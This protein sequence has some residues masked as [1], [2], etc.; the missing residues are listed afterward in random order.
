[1]EEAAPITTTTT[2]TSPSA[3]TTTSPSA[4]AVVAA[5]MTATGRVAKTT[6][7][8][9]H[10]AAVEDDDDGLGKATADL[11]QLNLHG[12]HYDHDHDDDSSIGSIGSGVHNSFDGIVE[13]P[14]G[15]NEEDIAATNNANNQVLVATKENRWVW[16]LRFL[17]TLIMGCVMIAVCVTVYYLSRRG[18]K[19]DFEQDF[20][21]IGDKLVTSFEEEIL[22][23]IGL[24]ESFADEITANAQTTVIMED[25]NGTI[26]S[27]ETRTFPFVTPNSF[28]R[29]SFVVAKMAQLANVVWMPRVE[30]EQLQEWNQYSAT[31]PNWKLEGMAV[32]LNVDP[33]TLEGNVSPLP[34]VLM[35]FHWGG[36]PKPEDGVGPYYVAWSITPVNNF[37][38]ANINFYQDLEHRAAIDRAYH[39]QKPSF[40]M[41]YHFLDP[42]TQEGMQY[43]FYQHNPYIDYQNDAFAVTFVPGKMKSKE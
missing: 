15:Y 29:R 13:D 26:T 36:P 42:T 24:L 12:S 31:S 28:A 40:E 41:S 10:D 4:A 35:N 8:D 20:L 27:I 17:T 23:R 22:L 6:H 7:P 1:M 32:A 2:T 34:P 16:R 5:Q 14:S 11:S 37:T 33:A 25:E 19:V 18:E 3:T 43:Q 9:H 39:T 38:M 21:D 30:T